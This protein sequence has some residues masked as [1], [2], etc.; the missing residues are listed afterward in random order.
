MLKELKSKVKELKGAN[1]QGIQEET[2][3]NRGNGDD[4]VPWWIKLLNTIY[5]RK[6][7]MED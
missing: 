7:D 1:D 3:K 5:V 4:D 6:K 2:G